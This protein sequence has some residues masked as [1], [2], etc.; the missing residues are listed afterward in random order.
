M[1]LGIGASIWAWSIYSSH[2][3]K[4]TRP[5]HLKKLP[6]VHSS[7]VRMVIIKAFMLH[8]EMLTLPTPETINCTQLP[9]KEVLVNTFLLH[10]G[11]WPSIPQKL[12]TGCCSPVRRVLLNLLNT[13]LLC[14]IMM[15]D[16]ILYWFYAGTQSCWVHECEGPIKSKRHSFSWVLPDLWLL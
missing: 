5:P 4:E 2:T 11:M 12:P 7:P 10:D 8:A 16:L 3:L 14:A 1:I 9:S 15:N 13:F 6:A